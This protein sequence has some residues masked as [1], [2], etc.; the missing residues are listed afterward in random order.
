MARRV[1]ML[2]RVLI[3][4]AVTAADVP[5]FQTLAQMN[6]SVPDLEA[7]FAAVCARRYVADPVKMRAMCHRNEYPVSGRTFSQ[8]TGCIEGGTTG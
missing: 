7:I 4:G 6:P 5:A 3:L 2:R 8:L 1:E